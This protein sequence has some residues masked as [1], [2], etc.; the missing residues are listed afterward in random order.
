MSILN[1]ITTRK[2]AVGFLVLGVAILFLGYQYQHPDGFSWHTLTSDLYANI[3]IDFVSIAITVLG[4]D[5][6]S[7]RREARLEKKRLIREMSNRDNG[8]ALRAVKELR[9]YGYLSDGS[10]HHI[11]LSG[12][13]LEVAELYSA[14][15]Q[16][17]NLNYSNLR[18]AQ[19]FGAN[20]KRVA[21][22][23]TNLVN[24]DIREANLSGANF[25]YA[26]LTKALVTRK[27]LEK[28]YSLRGSVLPNGKIYDGSFQLWGDIVEAKKAGIDV[29]DSIALSQWYAMPYDDF[30]HS[31]NLR[32]ERPEFTDWGLE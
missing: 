3:G 24:A 29:N 2:V 4:I 15:L 32:K 22:W 17:V 19:L 9:E 10:L 20:L 28:S 27:Q 31:Y 6:L 13:N 5:A 1:V 30:K 26:N 7:Q 16:Y 25:K 11:W 23:G 12:A 21:F 8:I 14:D 18:H